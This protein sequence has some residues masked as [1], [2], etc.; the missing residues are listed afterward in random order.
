MKKPPL[1]CHDWPAWASA[2]MWDAE[3]AQEDRQL[4]LTSS[5]RSHFTDFRIRESAANSRLTRMLSR[6]MQSAPISSHICALRNRSTPPKTEIRTLSDGKR[7]FTSRRRYGEETVT[8]STP[9]STSQP[10]SSSIS[11][12]PTRVISRLP[13]HDALRR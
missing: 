11:A 10:Q 3:R 6:T 13:R 1:P 2:F 9:I 7:T 8:D 4:L 5:S 12:C